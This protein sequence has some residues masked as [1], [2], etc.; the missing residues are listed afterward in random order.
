MGLSVVIKNVFN[1]NI[2]EKYQYYTIKN[3]LWLEIISFVVTSF[4]FFNLHFHKRL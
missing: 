3:I 1:Y 4:I 2:I